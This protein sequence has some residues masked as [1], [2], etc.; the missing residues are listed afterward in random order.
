[1]L[2]P[3]VVATPDPSSHGSDWGGRHE[4][5]VEMRGSDAAPGRRRLPRRATDRVEDAVAWLLAAAALVLLVIAGSVGIAVHARQVEA[6]SAGWQTQAVLLEDAEVI[7]AAEPD[8]RLPVRV[9][10]RWSDRSGTEHT[11][12]IKVDPAARAG[13]AVRVWLDA[14]G[15]VNAAPLGGGYA[16]ATGIIIAA[17]VL[18][19]GGGVLAAAW[20]G[21]RCVTAACNAPRWE[22]EWERV[23]PDWSA[24]LL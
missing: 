22:R 24:R 17:M 11:G 15:R 1:V 13:T 5:A 10:A 21:V 23:G 7:S 2:V 16:V 12:G 20:Y 18:V 4:E 6:R 3:P 8:P 9:Q 14:E 19:L